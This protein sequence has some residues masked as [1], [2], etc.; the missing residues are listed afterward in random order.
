MSANAARAPSLPRG[1]PASLHPPVAQLA[2]QA[3]L[4]PLRLD[5]AVVTSAAVACANRP[6]AP[7]GERFCHVAVL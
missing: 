7:S 1:A 3:N 2:R 6:S 4:T 5:C